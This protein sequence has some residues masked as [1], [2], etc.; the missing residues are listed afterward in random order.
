MI[1]S[2]VIII[3]IVVIGVM[4]LYLLDKIWKDEDEDKDYLG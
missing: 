2:R 1:K 4:F 3:A